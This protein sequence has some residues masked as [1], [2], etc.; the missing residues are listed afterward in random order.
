MV[1]Y[2]HAKNSTDQHEGKIRTYRHRRCP[3][4]LLLVP[5]LQH[6]LSCPAAAVV[7][8]RVGQHP[9]QRRLARI[10]VPNHGHAHVVVLHL[11]RQERRHGLPPAVACLRRPHGGWL[12]RRRGT[13]GRRSG[14]EEV[15]RVVVVRRGV[16]DGRLLP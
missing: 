5:V 9:N 14:R 4:V 6:Q 1:S 7:E 11:R 12:R 3:P 16:V 13:R 15:G 8:R 10:H 2:I